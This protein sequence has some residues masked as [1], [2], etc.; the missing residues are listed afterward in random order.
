MTGDHLRD[1]PGRLT[2][3]EV[4]ALGRWSISTFMH[5]RRTGKFL[6]EPIDRG[7]ELLFP[8]DP[9]LRALGLITD[10]P[11]SPPAV[12]PEKPIFSSEAFRAA[13][14]RSVRGRPP[15]S[16][17]D[18]AGSVRGAGATPSLRLVVDTPASD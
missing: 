7:S 17:R 11:A 8:R 6:V 3:S 12:E 9:V 5:R 13:G 14:S 2:T 10:D 15:K 16:G 4:C 1:L 18:M